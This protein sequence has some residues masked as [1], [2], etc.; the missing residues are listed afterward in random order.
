M[1]ALSNWVTCG[2]AFQACDRCSA[3]LRRM[4]VIGLRSTAPHF[5]KSGSATE[6]PE[7][8]ATLAW[9]PP[10]RLDIT[11]LVKVLTSSWLMRPPGPVPR[12]WSEIDAELAGQ[13]AHRRR[14]RRQRA[15]VGGRRSRTAGRKRQHLVACGRPA[16]RPAP[17]AAADLPRSV[18]PSPSPGPALKLRS[19]GL[20]PS[21]GP[22]A[23][24]PPPGLRP[25]P[26][27]TPLPPSARARRRARRGGRGAVAGARLLDHQHRLAR[28]HLV[29]G[30]D[31]HFLDPAGHGR[32]HFERRLVGFELQHRLI[33][34]EHVAG[35]HHH[36]EHVARG[37]TIAQV[38][39]N[40]LFHVATS[41]PRRTRATR[42]R[43]PPS[44]CR[45]PDP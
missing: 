28:L 35:L 11:C 43:D 37:H 42:R 36:A 34:G 2:M 15:A 13:P 38:G 30:L 29:A 12:T 27:A 26:V 19:V 39:E 31:P 4:P 22:L 3:V 16:P 14:G 10:P 1:S 24:S 25:P 6:P 21:P 7:S 20:S 23:L 41:R 18:G 44:R 33:G 9:P 17:R 32:R 5:E 40:E 8:V 45:C